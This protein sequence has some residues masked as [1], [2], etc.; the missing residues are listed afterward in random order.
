MYNLT[1]VSRMEIWPIERLIPLAKNARTHSRKQVWQ[2]A[3]SMRDYGVINP[4][5]VDQHGNVIAGH[6]RIL[7]A[8]FLGLL[9]LPVMALATVLSV[10]VAGLTR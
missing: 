5:L 6:G 10:M 8:Q 9:Q 1:I 2:I 4:V 7:A 3:R